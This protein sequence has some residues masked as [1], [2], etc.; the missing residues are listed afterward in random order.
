MAACLARSQTGID[1][2]PV[3]G[4]RSFL[5][6][7]NLI[8]FRRHGSCYPKSFLLVGNNKELGLPW[9][10]LFLPTNLLHDTKLGEDA[11]I[12]FFDSGVWTESE[13]FNDE[14][15]GPIP[16]SRLFSR[17][18]RAQTVLNL[19]PWVISV[20]ASSITRSFPTHIILGNNRT[21]MGQAMFY[22][23]DTGFVGLIYRE[24]SELEDQKYAAPGADML[25]AR[26]PSP[27]ARN[28]YAF[29]SG[30]S[31]AAP[32]VSGIVA[33]LEVFA[34]RLVSGC[35]T[36][37]LVTTAWRT[38]PHSGEPILA[39]LDITK[40]ADPFDFGGGL[41]NPNRARNPG[42]MFDLGIED[43]TYYL[44]SIAYIETAINHLTQS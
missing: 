9:P 39:E 37:A 6:V 5:L 14:G 24:K 43:H 11:I 2:D 19:A 33:L 41:V 25:A 42:L 12:G 31:M 35:Y 18:F 40:I 36:S 13:S 29:S 8:V 38:D 16:S 7:V 44:C 30:T 22:G 26:P 21:L 20:R 17:K 28:G 1:L 4:S 34:S 23:K 3:T 15:L 10:L 27:S 32:H